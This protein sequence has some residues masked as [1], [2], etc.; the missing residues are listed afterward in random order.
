MAP[1][2]LIWKN[3]KYEASYFEQGFQEINLHVGG[4]FNLLQKQLFPL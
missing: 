1:E 3:E 4:S 2:Y